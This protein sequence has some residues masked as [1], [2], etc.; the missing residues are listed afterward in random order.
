MPIHGAPSPPICVRNE[1]V[2][3]GS[4]SRIAIVWQPIPP[5]AACPSSSMVD[6]LCGQPEQ[7]FGART[8]NS[9][10]GRSCDFTQP[11]QARQYALR[12]MPARDHLAQRS[13]DPVGIQF[14]HGRE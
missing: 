4:P 8:L 13:R 11:V 14:A 12:R 5:P 1:N 7:K 3:F 9:S 10:F 2:R 6:R